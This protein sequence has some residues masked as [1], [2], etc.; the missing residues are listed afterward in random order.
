MEVPDEVLKGSTLLWEDFSRK[1][2]STAPHVAKVHVN[3]NKIW[4]VKDKSVKIDAFVV[5]DV[6]I[7]FRIRDSSVQFRVLRRGMW[8]IA[9]VPMIVSKWSPVTE[10]AQPEIKSILMWVVL[11]NVPHKMFSWEGLSFLSSPV[12][13]PKRLHPDTKLCSINWR[14]Q[15]L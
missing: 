9:D 14:K 13:D 5:N 4:S 10:E 1:F 3:V 7:K 11:K 8:N 6:T 2:L 15:R 12:G